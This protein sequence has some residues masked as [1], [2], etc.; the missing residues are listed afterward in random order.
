MKKYSYQTF[1]GQTIIRVV[2]DGY[3]K[4]ELLDEL[5]M[6][7]EGKIIS[8]DEN[9][10]FTGM[11][12]DQLRKSSAARTLGSIRTEKKAASSRE[13]G[14]RGG[15]P[16]SPRAAKNL[17]DL[18]NRLNAYDEDKMRDLNLSDLPVFG[19]R[20]EPHDTSEVYSWDD[21]YVLVADYRGSGQ[22]GLQPR[23]EICGEADFHCTC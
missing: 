23:C 22:W 4:S 21:K 13:N 14:R 6:N 15:R 9:I 7:G 11:T 20:G 12:I 10:P 8:D 5:V 2:E 19:K 18:M 16:R 17:I 1:P 3:T